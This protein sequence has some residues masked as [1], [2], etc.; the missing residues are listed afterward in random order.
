VRTLTRVRNDETLYSAMA[1]TSVYLGRPPSG[2]LHRSL[3]G[4]KTPVLDSDLPVGL[5]HVVRS[6][7]FGPANLYGAVNEWTLFPYYSHYVSPASADVAAGAMAGTG[8]WPHEVLGSWS[9][10]MPPPDRLRFCLEC[11]EEMLELH[12]D[13]WW[14]RTHQLPSTMVCPEHGVRLRLSPATRDSRR[15]AYVPASLE[16]CRSDAPLV[17]GKQEERVGHD[18]LVIARMGDALLDRECDEQPEDR[19]MRYLD[20]LNRLALLNKEGA[21]NLQRLARAM[22]GYWGTTLDVWQGLRRDGRCAQG[23][24]SELLWGG[25]ACAPLYHLLLDGLL[26]GRLGR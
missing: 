22:D 6:G 8:R 9:T 1:R 23:W 18:L 25:R 3:F 10:A 26:N 11:R 24:L 12:P 19:R 7:A 20:R 15:D 2:R 13:L 5:D 4:A 16:I 14:R 21:A 17:V